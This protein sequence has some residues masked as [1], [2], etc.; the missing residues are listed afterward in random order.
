MFDSAVSAVGLYSS[1]V[2]ADDGG[3]DEMS[4]RVVS[5]ATFV[6]AASLV[7][8]SSIPFVGLVFSVMRPVAGVAPVSVFI[9]MDSVLVV[10][11]FCLVDCLSVGDGAS[12]GEGDSV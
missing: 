7:L 8:H 2:S 12:F 10:V 9:E 5:V 4:I 6:G 11:L 3:I 1:F